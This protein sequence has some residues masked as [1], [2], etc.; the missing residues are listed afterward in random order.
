ME[1]SVHRNVV[2]RAIEVD[3]FPYVVNEDGDTFTLNNIRWGSG[4]SFRF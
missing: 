2:V 3:Y 1:I 4:V